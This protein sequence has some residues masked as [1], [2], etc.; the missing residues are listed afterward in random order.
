VVG[1]RG[2]IVKTT[3]GGENWIKLTSKTF[4]DLRSV[5]FLDASTGYAVGDTGIIVKTTDAG[6]TWTVQSSGTSIGLH[7]VFF[8]D[9]STGYV[10]GDSGT[11][12]KTN[13]AG[14]TWIALL[15][16]TSFG[17]YSVFF[18]DANTGYA[19]GDSGTI[20]KTDDAG[21]TW[22]IQPS[23]TT[24]SLT[25]VHFVDADTGYIVGA[26]GTILKTTNGGGAMTQI[27]HVPGDYPTIQQGINAASNG[28]TVLVSDGTYYE[29]ISFLGKKPLMV[30]SEFL[31]TGDMNHIANTII[32]GSQIINPDSGSIVY[33]VSGEDTTSILCG[34]TLRNG[35]IGTSA[36]YPTGGY[37][38]SGGAVY[39][40]GSGAKIMYNHITQ[41][42]LNGVGFK[43]TGAGISAGQWWED[44]HWVVIEHNTIDNNSCYSD[45][46]QTF[47][48]GICVTCNTRITNNV[49]SDNINHGTGSATGAAAGIFAGG[50][51][52]WQSLTA[53]VINNK[54]KN[55]VAISEGN[56]GGGAGGVFQCNSVIFQGNIVEDNEVNTASSSGGGVLFWAP[57]TG[58]IFSGNT[59]RHNIINGSGGGLY[60]EY[61]S[62]N[63]GSDTVLVENN[64]FYENSATTGGGFTTKNNPAVLQNNVFNG[65][66]A[67][68]QGGACYLQCA[69][70]VQDHKSVLIN[71]SFYN[72]QA[73]IGGAIRSNY[74]RPLILNSV[75]WNDAAETGPEIYMTGGDPLEIAY[76]DI[77]TSL[78]TIIGGEVID[79]GGNINEDP[80]YDDMELL[81]LTTGSPC[82]NTGTEE[83]TCQCGDH[84]LAPPYDIEGNPR[85]S[86]GGVDMGAH[87]LLEKGI[88]SPAMDP[89]V[90]NIYPNPLIGSTTITYLL[91]HDDFVTLA[92]YDHLGRQVAVLSTGSQQAGIHQVYW[93]PEGMP[94]GIYYC[95]LTTGNQSVAGKL[96]VTR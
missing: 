80:L 32:D 1:N 92:V 94:A 34:F 49:I 69:P 81:T 30:A 87:E 57:R 22:K 73:S 55:N 70:P 41:N 12:L 76:S 42:S 23:G 29:Q 24:T 52:Y 85:P 8:T 77:D 75:F 71:N 60:L 47:G 16:G 58:S 83:F 37:L 65:N 88:P 20:L 19:V 2:I 40:F 89:A 36:A 35:N 31:I 44:S 11:I 13:D 45:S 7:S 93:A 54:I 90:L 26:E 33:F 84:F 66:Q 59:F 78:I 48:T 5:Y 4:P 6:A 95:R 14:A 28:D 50:E 27:I 79:G 86:S 46:Q 9:A 18:T 17:L 3:D 64:Y 56:Y 61:V 21:A 25:S 62:T 72:N 39:I 63:V 15:N 67:S 38:Q 74:A 51:L 91:R 96:I 53:V 68:G 10:V 43:T 82:V